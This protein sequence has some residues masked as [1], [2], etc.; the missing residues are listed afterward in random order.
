MAYDLVIKWPDEPS[1]STESY[2]DKDTLLRRVEYIKQLPYD[3]RPAWE[4]VVVQATGE[5]IQ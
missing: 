2:L 3:E 1:E 4:I 5:V